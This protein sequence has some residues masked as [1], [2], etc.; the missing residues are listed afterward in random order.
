MRLHQPPLN[1]SINLHQLTP[2]TREEGAPPL[3]EGQEGRPRPPH[4]RRHGQA[5]ISRPRLPVDAIRWNA[6][7][8]AI[9]RWNAAVHAAVARARTP[10]R[11]AVSRRPPGPQLLMYG[12][13]KLYKCLLS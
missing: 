6:A 10:V 12:P 13:K 1:R 4:P 2:L 8:D 11:P 9:P 3:Q 7:V 5:A